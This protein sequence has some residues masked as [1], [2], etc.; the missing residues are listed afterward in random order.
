MGIAV[1]TPI[2]PTQVFLL[3]MSGNGTRVESRRAGTARPAT[4]VPVLVPILPHREVVEFDVLSDWNSI[5]VYFLDV[6]AKFVSA[7]REGALVGRVI[8][9]KPEQRKVKHGVERVLLV[10]VVGRRDSVGVGVGVGIII[11]SSGWCRRDGCGRCSDCDCSWTNSQVASATVG[12]DGTYVSRAS[13]LRG[14]VSWRGVVWAQSWSS[15]KQSQK[16]LWV[17]HRRH[18]CRSQLNTMVDGWGW[19]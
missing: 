18:R 14:P 2:A 4:F 5:A 15:Q 11:R 12:Y 7:A 16:E 3:G 17:E 19:L 9:Q 10:S 1:G 13:F 8:R 6:R